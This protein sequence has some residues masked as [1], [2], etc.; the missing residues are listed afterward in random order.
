MIENEDGT[1]QKKVE[2]IAEKVTF[3]SSAGK[4]KNI[5]E[6]KNETALEEK[7]DKKQKS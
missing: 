3:L 5:D 6:N 1:K 2:M 4:G 7:K